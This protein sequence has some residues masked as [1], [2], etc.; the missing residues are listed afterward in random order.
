MAPS[1][2]IPEDHL[3]KGLNRRSLHYATPDFLLRLEALASFMG[4]SLLRRLR[5]NSQDEGHGFSRAVK[6][7]DWRGLQPLRYGFTMISG[8]FPCDPQRRTSGAKALMAVAFYGTAKAVP[9][10]ERVF[11]QPLKAAYMAVGERSVVEG[12]AAFPD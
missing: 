5:K 10:V 11:P 7:R 1:Q 3:N 2:G 9:F 6:V 4:L 8:E 12:P